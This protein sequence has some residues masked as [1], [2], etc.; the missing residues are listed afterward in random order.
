ML[1]NFW[2]KRIVITWLIALFLVLPKVTQAAIT[3]NIFGWAWNPVIGWI[4]MNNC[5]YGA[6]CSGGI[7][8]GAN[9]TESGDYELTGY[10]WNNNVG[11]ISL[12][13]GYPLGGLPAY[14][15][16]FDPVS[17]QFSG[18]AKIVS[19]GDDGWI[20]FAK[21][22]Y[23]S[24][25]EYYVRI[26]SDGKLGGWAWNNKIG[27]LS[28]NS[29]DWAS[30]TIT[31]YTI[32]RAPTMPINVSVVS[33]E[34]N[35]CNTLNLAWA[36]SSYVSVYNVYRFLNPVFTPTS[37]NHVP[38]PLSVSNKVDSGLAMG[39]TYCYHIGASNFFGTT[40]TSSS[41][42]GQTKSICGITTITGSGNCLQ[43]DPSIINLRWVKPMV[44]S[45]TEITRFEVKR[46]QVRETDDCR[47]SSSIYNLV[48]TS[49]DCYI[50]KPDEIDNPPSTTPA[51]L[52]T[53]HCVDQD[54]H[55]R[56]AFYGPE[57]A[58]Q[59]VYKIVAFDNLGHSGDET[60]P[61]ALINI[62]PCST[63]KSWRWEEQ[64]PA[65]TTLNN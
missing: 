38:P 62:F 33:D 51:I 52:P 64:N 8:Y 7:D 26:G 36:T 6:G 2:K 25:S 34:Y 4:S 65:S 61:K 31:Y 59:Y 44:A 32:G 42:C 39:G 43:G 28:F 15:V 46:C 11:W 35:G 21:D 12:S 37:S 24:G 40:F 48:S 54:C 23:D 56:E 19:L 10:I 17:R 47:Q 30:N 1:L 57:V 63:Q 3:D 50:V 58:E 22:A 18:W 9:L 5:E 55:C 49:S 14:S 27:W 13:A 60:D 29:A 16:R 20:K 41:T 53:R 45:G